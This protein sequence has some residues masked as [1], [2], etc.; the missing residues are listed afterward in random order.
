MD[1]EEIEKKLKADAQ[2]IQ[3]QDF[4]V[5]WQEL[6]R[7]LD[8]TKQMEEKAVVP[9]LV[10]ASASNGSSVSRKKSIKYPFKIAIIFSAV[11]SVLLLAIVLPIVLSNK[12]P[13]IYYN[14]A[15]LSCLNVE[16][17]EFY[18]GIDK[19]GIEIVD[20]S[21]YEVENFRLYLSESDEVKGGGFEFV[22]EDLGCFAIVVFYDSSVKV[23]ESQKNY[24][25]CYVGDT[26]IQYEIEQM[27][28]YYSLSA[29]TVFE[30]IYYR[31]NCD[32]VENNVYDIFDNFLN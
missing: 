6:Q 21:E 13:K 19:A 9:D 18:E 23:N 5:R 24:E 17:P 2:K 27:D 7:R 8:G 10:Q 31:F 12:A 26:K 28:G 30:G 15:Q 1:Y 32:M 14:E 22:D 3:R 16:S 25:L 20:L 29:F 11:F 4:S